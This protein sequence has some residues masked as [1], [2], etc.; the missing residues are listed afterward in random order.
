MSFVKEKLALVLLIFAIVGC[1]SPA[2]DDGPE[3]PPTGPPSVLFDPPLTTVG[4]Y[5][6]TLDVDGVHGTCSGT[7]TRDGSDDVGCDR[8]SLDLVQTLKAKDPAPGMDPSESAE[9][10][11]SKDFTALTIHEP[12]NPKEVTL[13]IT[14]N[15]NSIVSGTY[16]FRD[17][18]KENR[19]GTTTVMPAVEL[20]LGE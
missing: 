4:E 15:G 8:D 11:P 2:R 6:F 14:L 18:A 1:E 17:I 9:Y 13:T 19:C 20:D 16:S 7:I 10:L 3:C 5:E 12:E